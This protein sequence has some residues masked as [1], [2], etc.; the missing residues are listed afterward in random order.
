MTKT[1][2]SSD[3][4]KMLLPEEIMAT[5]AHALKE[6]AVLWLRSDTTK[7]YAAIIVELEGEGMFN[8]VDKVENVIAE[9]EKLTPGVPEQL[10]AS[11]RDEV[12]G[13]GPHRLSVYVNTP[14]GAG[15]AQVNA[16]LVTLRPKTANQAL[17]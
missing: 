5:M 13:G 17:N 10:K 11:L 9:L 2:E 4:N 14:K 7:K 1:E 8:F 12:P 3:S 6:A 15:I 16:A